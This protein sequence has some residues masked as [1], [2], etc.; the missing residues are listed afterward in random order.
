MSDRDFEEGVRLALANGAYG[1][2]VFKLNNINKEKFAIIQ[3]VF[4]ES[5]LI[6]KRNLRRR[7]LE[8]EDN[9]HFKKDLLEKKNEHFHDKSKHNY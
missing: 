9:S 5:A 7:T 2:S 4:K 6:Q 8:S 3:Q 1:I